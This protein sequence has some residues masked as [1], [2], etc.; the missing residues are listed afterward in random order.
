MY[1]KSKTVSPDFDSW[2]LNEK[3]IAIVSFD[4]MNYLTKYFEKYEIYEKNIVFN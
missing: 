3:F 2:N 1:R 4:T